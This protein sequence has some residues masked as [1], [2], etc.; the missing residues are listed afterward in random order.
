[1]TKSTNPETIALHGGDYRKDPATNP[2]F[3][4]YLFTISKR[5]NSNGPSPSDS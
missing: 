5:M 4:E 3:F 2:L 1:M